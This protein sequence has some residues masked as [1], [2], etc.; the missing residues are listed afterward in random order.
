MMAVVIR[1]E[2]EICEK[3]IWEM[4]WR[5]EGSWEM[6]GREVCQGE[7]RREGELGDDGERGVSRTVEARREAGR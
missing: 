7:L 6:M 3:G 5:E 4:M 1:G 2:E